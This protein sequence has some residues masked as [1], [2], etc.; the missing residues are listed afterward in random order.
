MALV[1]PFGAPALFMT[2]LYSNY[3]EIDRI[4]RAELSADGEELIEQQQGGSVEQ[5][6]AAAA[7][8]SHADD[9]AAPMARE[10]AQSLRN[11]L[12]PELK[13]LTNNYD[14][15]CYWFM[16]FEC[17]R[18]IALLGLP[19]ALPAGSTGQLSECHNNAFA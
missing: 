19:L 1:Y 17:M 16:I 9:A 15:R 14:M 13:K 10:R 6:R 7:A 18:K 5:S 11:R 3:D 4:R 2:M 12:S 8:A